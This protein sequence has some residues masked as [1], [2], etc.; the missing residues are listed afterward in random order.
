M[1]LRPGGD[2]R[3]VWL[4][5]L[6][7]LAGGSYYVQERYQAVITASY[8]NDEKLY[9][10][11]VANV[12]IVR[13][14]AILHAVQRQAQADLTRLSHDS[15]LSG[16][17]ASMLLMLHSSAKAFDTR[18]LEVRPGDTQTTKGDALEATPVTIRV[19]GKFRN[20]LALIEDLPHHQTLVS[21][22]DTEMAIAGEGDSGMPEPTLD[23]TVHATMY[24]L[25]TADDKEPRVAARE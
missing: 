3:A 15:S 8:Q 5:T 22:S 19:R 9:R 17:T 13:E 24:R 18:I 2:V 4:L 21:V 14:A 7:V 16:T 10:G 1:R 25:T 12:R 23:A 6:C 11:T 20:I